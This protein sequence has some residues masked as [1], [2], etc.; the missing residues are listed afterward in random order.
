MACVIDRRH[1][2]AFV[3]E[4]EG[5][6]PMRFGVVVVKFHMLASL[7]KWETTLLARG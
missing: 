7:M 2:A 1:P 6:A 4:S 3:A 5:I